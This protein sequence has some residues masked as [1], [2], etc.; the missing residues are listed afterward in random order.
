MAVITSKSTIGVAAVVMA[1][2]CVSG[3]EVLFIYV[4]VFPRPE[5]QVKEHGRLQII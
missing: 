3:V 1:S 2:L 5:S 4:W